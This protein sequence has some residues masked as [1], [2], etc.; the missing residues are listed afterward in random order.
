MVKKEKKLVRKEKWYDKAKNSKGE[1]V[2]LKWYIGCSIWI[3]LCFTVVGIGVILNLCETSVS[4]FLV[5]LLALL[6]VVIGILLA[7]KLI[8]NEKYYEVSKKENKDKKAYGGNV[9]GDPPIRE[10]TESYEKWEEEEKRRLEEVK[11]MFDKKKK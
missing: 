11:K 6:V 9:D 4:C 10:G 7:E 1:E 8:K 3:T 2:E 5:A